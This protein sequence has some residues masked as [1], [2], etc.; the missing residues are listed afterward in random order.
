MAMALEAAIPLGDSGRLPSGDLVRYDHCGNRRS[1]S[2]GHLCTLSHNVRSPTALSSATHPS[3]AESG[4]RVGDLTGQPVSCGGQSGQQSD[5][6]QQ[7][8]NAQMGL[9]EQAEGGA[10][11]GADERHD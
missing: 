8:A 11:S 2:S 7:V 5:N 6:R 3:V 1:A 9:S 4:S 10:Q